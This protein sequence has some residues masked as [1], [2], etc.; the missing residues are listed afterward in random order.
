MV[1]MKGFN[2]ETGESN[3]SLSGDFIW[4]NGNV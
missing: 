1:D 3:D 4:D 2:P